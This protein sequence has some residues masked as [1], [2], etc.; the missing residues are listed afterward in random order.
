MPTTNIK[1]KLEKQGFEIRNVTNIRSWKT[2]ES[3]PLF[4]VDQAL[5][6]KNEEMYELKHLLN[7]IMT[8]LSFVKRKKY[9]SVIA[10][11]NMDILRGIV[12]NHSFVWNVSEIIPQILALRRKTFLQNVYCV[13][14]RILRII[15][16][17][18][19]ID[20]CRK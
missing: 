19:C 1:D 15:K 4:L 13:A 20:N 6:E 11:K 10:V 14:V 3:L 7:T 9:L 17:A 16:D 2:K 8:Y 18:A 5:G 12:L